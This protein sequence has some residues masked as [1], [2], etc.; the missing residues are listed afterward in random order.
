M[1]IDVHCHLGYDLV[2]DEVI[3]EEMLVGAF[4]AN[5]V[6]IG[7]VQP[8]IVEPTHEPQRRIHDQ[9]FALTQEYPGRFYGMASLN[10]HCGQEFYRA[11]MK[12]C[13]TE[14]AFVGIKIS[15]IAHAVNPLSPDGR[16]A[17]DVSRE[18]KVPIMIHT[19]AGIPFALP[20][21]LL[22]LAKEYKDLPVVI[23]HSG[24]NIAAGE[25]LIVARECDNVFLDTSWTAP[26]ICKVFVK[27]LG[28]SKVMFAS[29]MF[30]NQ[31]VEVCKWR[32][33]GINEADLE[34]VLWKTTAQV[35]GIKP[36]AAPKGLNAAKGVV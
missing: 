16:M 19:G 20:A 36:G 17:F 3:T 25:A 11:E 30:D 15:P 26:H 10:P 13:M 14:L 8:L 29:D 2:F 35:Y 22:P 27:V 23:A 7:I 33:L 34:W 31:V 28:A 5:K 21:L 32:T 4:D 1:I 24:Q 6:D 9:V 18:L 12:R